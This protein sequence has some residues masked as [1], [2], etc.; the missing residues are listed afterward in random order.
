VEEEFDK[1][2]GNHQI[3]NK[4]DPLLLRFKEFIDTEW[5]LP[6]VTVQFRGLFSGGYPPIPSPAQWGIPSHLS[7]EELVWQQAQTYS[8]IEEMYPS[9]KMM[10]GDNITN[11][12]WA[13]QVLTVLAFHRVIHILP[14]LIKDV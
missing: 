6:A 12:M 9:I 4:E 13:A 10:L 3:V 11:T 8:F 5:G 1:F 14:M 7:I 2:L